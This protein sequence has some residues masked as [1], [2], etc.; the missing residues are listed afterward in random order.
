MTFSFHPEADFVR[1][2]CRPPSIWKSRLNP[3]P[4][5]QTALSHAK[6]VSG[7]C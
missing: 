1:S 6:T 2:R 5:I 3:A 7:Y 4:E